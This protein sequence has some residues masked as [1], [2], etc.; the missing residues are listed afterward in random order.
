MFSSV[1]GACTNM[2]MYIHMYVQCS[3]EAG[4]GV[5]LFVVHLT[6]TRVVSSAVILISYAQPVGSTKREYSNLYLHVGSEEFSGFSGSN[7][8]HTLYMYM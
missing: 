1:K 3:L 8:T 5:F 2:Y 4:T 7:Y 6:H